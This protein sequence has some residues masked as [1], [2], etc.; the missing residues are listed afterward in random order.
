MMSPETKGHLT[1]S[2]KLPGAAAWCVC[3]ADQPSEHHCYKDW[4]KPEQLEAIVSKLAGALAGLRLR[5]VEPVQLC[6]VFEHARLFLA[7]RANGETLVLVVE[8]RPNLAI[9]AHQAAMT[10]FAAGN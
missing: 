2:L 1:Q 5:Q 9:A 10:E 3:T 4:F 7:Q 6:W 8:N